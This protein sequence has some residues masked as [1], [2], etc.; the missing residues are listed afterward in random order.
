[1]LPPREGLHT[2]DV[3]GLPQLSV[4]IGFV[5]TADLFRVM[6]N[7]SRGCVSLY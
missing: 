4:N 5:E 6:L 1:M 7:R 3:N 2:T